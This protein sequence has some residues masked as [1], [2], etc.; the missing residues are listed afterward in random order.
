MAFV[1]HLNGMFAFAIWDSA[2]EELL[3]VR[4]RLGVKPSTTTPT[5]VASCSDPSPRRS[6]PTRCSRRAPARTSCKSC[7]TRG[8]PCPGRR[9]TPICARSSRATWCASTG[10]ARTRPRTGG[11]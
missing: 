10:P 4:D 11:W 7:S 5:P 8:S 6:W 1:D 2:R 9:P 3:L